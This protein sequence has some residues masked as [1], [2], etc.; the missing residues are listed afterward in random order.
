[1]ECQV[2]QAQPM[3]TGYLPPQAIAVLR[4][5]ASGAY[6]DNGVTT[7]TG[8]ALIA[9][10]DA[11][12]IAYSR[13]PNQVPALALGASASGLLPQFS[14]SSCTVLYSMR[15]LSMSAYSMPYP[16]AV[17]LR[18]GPIVARA[19]VSSCACIQ[20]IGLMVARS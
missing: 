5:K 12:S 4:E 6:D 7:S 20:S 19:T 16:D 9:D 15:K 10:G 3:L 2:D 1:M 18:R 13:T 8:G 11:K 14:A 17:Q